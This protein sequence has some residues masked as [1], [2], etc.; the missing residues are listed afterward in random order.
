MTQQIQPSLT[1]V[2]AQQLQAVMA[3]IMAVWVGAFVLSQVIKVF[4]GE[5]IE[6][7]PLLG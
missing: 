2:T 1:Q 3:G 5:V 7:P 6:K 4:K